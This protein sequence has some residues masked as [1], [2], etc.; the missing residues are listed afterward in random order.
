[1]GRKRRDRKRE[2][3]GE[4]KREKNNKRL[5]DGK[6]RQ[7]L[8]HCND[9]ATDRS[10]RGT[11]QLCRINSGKCQLMNVVLTTSIRT[12][13]ESGRIPPLEEWQRIDKGIDPETTNSEYSNPGDS[14]GI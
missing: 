2:R 3:E 12:G 7:Y 9:L 1:M 5:R 13:K 11:N 14:G 6:K 8:P 4:I 10:D